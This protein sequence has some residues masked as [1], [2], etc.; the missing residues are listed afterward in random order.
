MPEMHVFK[1]LRFKYI[2]GRL[3]V[4]LHEWWELHLFGRYLP[5]AQADAA[6][7]AID[8]LGWRFRPRPTRRAANSPF[9]RLRRPLAR[10]GIY[11]RKG[12]IRSLR[13]ARI[14]CE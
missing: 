14:H 3:L 4:L 5:Q 8:Q 1:L 11:D 12:C 7:R 10:S 6:L 9:E 2:A 13:D